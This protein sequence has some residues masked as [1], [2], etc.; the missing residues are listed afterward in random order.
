VFPQS[1]DLF[2]SI[3]VAKG[4]SLRSPLTADLIQLAT[5]YIL[6][7]LRQVR[8]ARRRSSSMVLLQRCVSS[9]CQCSGN[10]PGSQLSLRC[11]IGLS[12]CKC[13]TSVH[14]QLP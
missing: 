13:V 4:V 5:A 8:L 1:F 12:M 11:S 7:Q 10:H 14:S 2:F 3:S 6:T 9:G